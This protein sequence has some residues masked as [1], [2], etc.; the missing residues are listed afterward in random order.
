MGRS[1]RDNGSSYD[2]L[3]EYGIIIGLLSKKVLDYTT[4]NCQCSLC[5]KNNEKADHDCRR[6]F[7]GSAKTM[8]AD[9]EVELII[10]SSTRFKIKCWC[11][12]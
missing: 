1:K 4:R 7:E 10:R 12:D 5:H 11:F 8:E 9:A 2:S 3:N 6:N